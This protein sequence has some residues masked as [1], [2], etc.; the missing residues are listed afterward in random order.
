MRLSKISGMK[1]A[2]HIYDHDKGGILCGTGFWRDVY[3][4][5]KIYDD[6]KDLLYSIGK[7]TYPCS[8]CMCILERFRTGKRKKE[9]NIDKYFKS[10]R[11]YE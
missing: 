8:R 11:I 10:K 2:T 1:T 9:M 7:L 3:L 6:P 5:K 4:R